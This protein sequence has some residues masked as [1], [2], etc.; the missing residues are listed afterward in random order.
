MIGDGERGRKR[1][2][3]NHKANEMNGDAAR[4]DQ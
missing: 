2:V 4:D 1:L 3:E